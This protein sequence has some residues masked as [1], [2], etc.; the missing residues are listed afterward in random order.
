MHSPAM[1][2]RP[3]HAARP[4]GLVWLV[5]IVLILALTGCAF[6]GTPVSSRADLDETAGLVDRLVAADIVA[7]ACSGC[8]SFRIEH[9]SPW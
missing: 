9:R 7:C 2:V 6:P 5:A 4:E 3:D 8:A 1:S